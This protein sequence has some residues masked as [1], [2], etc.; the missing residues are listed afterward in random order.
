MKVEGVHTTQMTIF[1][2]FYIKK[3]PSSTKFSITNNFNNSTT[4]L[5][6]ATQYQVAVHYQNIFNH[7]CG[8][9]YQIIFIYNSDPHNKYH[10][11]KSYPQLF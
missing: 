1:F 8:D 3:T 6:N 4:K 5:T 9:H 7:M 2:P 10:A 11:N